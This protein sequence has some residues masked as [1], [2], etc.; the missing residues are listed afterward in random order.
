MAG[1][2]S[3]GRMWILA[4]T[5]VA[6]LYCV[7]TESILNRDSFRRRCEKLK[8]PAASEQWFGGPVWIHVHMFMLQSSSDLLR[9]AAVCVLVVTGHSRTQMCWRRKR[10]VQFQ[11][12]SGLRCHLLVVLKNSQ[13]QQNQTKTNQNI[14]SH[15]CYWLNCWKKLWKRV[16]Q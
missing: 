8:Y 4:S 1:I 6:C 12:S 16:V 3:L 13:Y 10:T 9:A 2:C 7:S 15:E 11:H 14:K 5:D